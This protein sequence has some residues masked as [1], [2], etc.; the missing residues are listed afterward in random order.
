MIIQQRD[1]PQEPNII[2]INFERAYQ[3]SH[4]LEE[5]KT[6]LKGCNLN[7]AILKFVLNDI[8]FDFYKSCN[9]TIQNK[10]YRISI[11][12]LL[13]SYQDIDKLKQKMLLKA[14]AQLR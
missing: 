14:R 6:F 8:Q 1:Q 2:T 7:K 11:P 4:A 10:K 5:K 9:L 13:R 12:K 3:N